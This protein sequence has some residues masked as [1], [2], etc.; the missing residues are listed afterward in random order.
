MIEVRQTDAFASWLGALRD[1]NARIRIATRIRR[2]ETGNPGDWKAPGDGLNE[3]RIDWG[4]GYR[5]YY[6]H[7]GGTVVILLCGGDKRT[8]DADIKR[9]RK[10]AEEV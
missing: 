2:L 8:Q 3:M 4:P 10:M 1:Q 6:I 5:L 7:R 9:A